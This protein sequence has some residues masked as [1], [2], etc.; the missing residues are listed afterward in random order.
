MKPF[1]DHQ[2]ET[3]KKKPHRDNSN[4]NEINTP[5]P[6]LVNTILSQSQIPSKITSLLVSNLIT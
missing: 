3:N 4:Y 2:Q 5:F 6:P 1:I